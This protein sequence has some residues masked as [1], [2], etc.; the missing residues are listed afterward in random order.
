[1]GEV[2]VVAGDL[3][4][5]AGVVE[6]HSS[7]V[8]SGL[9]NS[10]GLGQV[11]AGLARA[12]PHQ[13]LG[14]LKHL[15]LSNTS[16]L[17]ETRLVALV[18]E[19]DLSSLKSLRRAW[20]VVYRDLCSDDLGLARRCGGIVDKARG[21][22]DDVGT[23]EDVTLHEFCCVTLNGIVHTALT[24][25]TWVSLQLEVVSALRVDVDR[26]LPGLWFTVNG[27]SL[28]RSG[29]SQAQHNG[30]DELGQHDDWS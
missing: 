21:A 13:V 18:G 20:T 27:L 4:G 3:H 16:A 14:A 28:L 25:L 26:Q 11:D 1:V 30:N 29:K 17:I 10:H 23:T 5:C 15:S 12:I 19:E 7:G 2:V 8:D 6:L 9:D 22:L 24:A